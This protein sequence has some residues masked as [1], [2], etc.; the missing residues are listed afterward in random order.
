[1]DSSAEL[2]YGRQFNELLQWSTFLTSIRQGLS[3]SICPFLK[4]GYA[5]RQ[6]PAWHENS[7]VQCNALQG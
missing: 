5:T 7:R 6:V 1:M 3:Y 2:T 4:Q